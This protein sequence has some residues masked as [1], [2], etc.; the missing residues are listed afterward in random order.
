MKILIIYFTMTGRTK[1]MAKA[2]GSSFTD[3][4]VQYIPFELMVKMSERLK[5]IGRFDKGDFKDIENEL[6]S[7]SNIEYDLLIIGMPTHGNFPP[8]AFVQILSKLEN[9]SNKIVVVFNTARMT[10]G[11]SLDYME[12]KVKEMGAEVI[13]K[14][15]FKSMA[16]LGKKDAVEFG[17]K[18]SQKIKKKFL[19]EK[20]WS[21]QIY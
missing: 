5:I 7:L 13:D 1:K 21:I 19:V 17:V 20:N 2:I 8:K 15:R 9:L 4:E 11:K 3:H 12:T 6:N 16:H 18:I 10:G 14:R